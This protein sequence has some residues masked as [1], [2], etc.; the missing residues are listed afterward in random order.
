MQGEFAGP[1]STWSGSAEEDG[2]VVSPPAKLHAFS[3]SMGLI[4]HRDALGSDT[5]QEE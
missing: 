1:A 2:P 3:A 5:L 4:C